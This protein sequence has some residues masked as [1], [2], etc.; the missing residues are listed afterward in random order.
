[1]KRGLVVA[2]AGAAV[3]AAG[4]TGCSKDDKKSSGSSAT[5]SASASSAA[6]NS[7]AGSGTA[8]VT[9]DGKAQDV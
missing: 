1:M 7:T 8:K 4:L 2:V 3:L 5:A 6:G 9:I